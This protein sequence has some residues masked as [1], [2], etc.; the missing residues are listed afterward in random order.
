MAEHNELGKEGEERARE[1]LQLKGY[2]IRHTN[3][4][5]FGS[6][7]EL[8]IIAEKDGMLVVVEVKSRSSITFEHPLDAITSGKIKRIVDATHEY[9]FAYDL[10]IDTRFDVVAVLSDYK[11]GFVIEHI[12]DA[13]YPPLS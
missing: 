9:I 5:P 6:K 10:L 7:Y 3:W 4:R 13:F 1:Y 8:D 2:K 12:E 11:G